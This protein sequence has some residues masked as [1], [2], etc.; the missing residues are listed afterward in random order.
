M[1]TIDQYLESIE[2]ESKSLE[3]MPT[4]FPY[5]DQELNGGFM[6]KEL[7]ILGGFTGLGKSYVAGQMFWNIATTGYKSAYFSLEISGEMIVSRLVGSLCNIHPT[8]IVQNK[9]VLEKTEELDEAKM[10]VS[11]YSELMDIYDDLY[12]LDQITTAIVQGKYDFVVIDFI[13]NVQARGEEY[14]RLT[15]ISLAL[16]RLAKQQNCCILALSQLSNSAA[17]GNAVEYKGSGGI[18][19]VADLGFFLVRAENDTLSLALRKNRRGFSGQDF[20]LEFK[21]P[22]GQIYEKRK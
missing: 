11:T 13:Q 2:K 16:Q 15:S 7:I 18:A 5:L 17:R 9:V 21:K 8:L 6:K 1:K 19:M 3:I 22:G 14:E 12:G 10:K 4:G 20:T